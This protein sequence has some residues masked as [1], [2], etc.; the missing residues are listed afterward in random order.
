MGELLPVVIA[1]KVPKP[2]GH[3]FSDPAHHDSIY[4]VFPFGEG[5]DFGVGASPVGLRFALRFGKSVAAF[6]E[7]NGGLVAF[8][9]AMP[10]VNARSVNFLGSAGGGLRFGQLGHRAY[11]FGYRLAHI[12]NA[13]TALEN[14]GFN[15]HLIYFGMTLH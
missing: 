11:M 2:L 5:P 14:P 15:A 12:S 7:G 4:A 9:R 6:A 3:W 13:N 1:T 8:A 10:E